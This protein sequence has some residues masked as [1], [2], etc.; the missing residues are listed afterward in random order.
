MA[1]FRKR[2]PWW[3]RIAAKIVLSRLPI[4]YAVWKQIG[5]FEHGTMERPANAFEIFISLANAAHISGVRD[6]DFCSESNNRNPL[7]GFTVVEVGPGD[8][9]FSAL[10]AKSLGAQKCL[11]IDAG[12]FATQ[13]L[14]VYLEAAKFLEK[15]G[16]SVPW[17]TRPRSIGELMECCSA[18][19]MTKGL[20]SV[21]QIPAE[22]VDYIFSNAVLEHIAKQE[23]IQYLSEFA[24]ILKPGGISTHRVDLK[25]HLGGALNNLRF[26]DRVWESGLFTKSG[27]YTNR[28]RFSEML[29]LFQGAGL[30]VEISDS[31]QWSHLPT[32][33]ARMDERFRGLS[34]ED[35]LTKGFVVAAVKSNSDKLGQRRLK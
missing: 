5:L 4:S 31:F 32:P 29:D 35:L 24:R 34:D 14:D 7:D 15:N 21:E 18:E 16:L 17:L 9:L 2:F 1:R 26:S 12:T 28:I 33:R 23:F 30:E 13:K 25:D 11:L 8:S 6:K 3:F 10:L 22:S 20:K 27:F 19:Y